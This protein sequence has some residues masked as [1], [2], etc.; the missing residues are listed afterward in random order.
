MGELYDRLR[1]I[2]S[3]D[4]SPADTGKVEAAL[5]SAAKTFNAT[6]HWPFQLHASIG[7]SCGLADVKDGAATI[8]S[9]TQ[10]AHQLRPTIASS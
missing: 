5:A 1:K 4:R 3:N 10:G 7:P 6:Y 9:G 8:W 2:P